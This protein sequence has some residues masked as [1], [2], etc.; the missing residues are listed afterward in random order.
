MSGFPSDLLEGIR[1]HLEAEKKS[2]QARINELKGQDP[3]SDPDRLND[4]A[5]TD[6]EANEESSHDR[7]SA[8]VEELNATLTQIDE[9]LIR[10][11]NGTYGSCS[12]CGKMINTD[13]LNIL[14]HAT[15][16]L[17][18]ERIKKRQK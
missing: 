16:C 5:A 8:M 2:A 13:R 11:G 6:A 14:A 3:F 15:L 1:I 10:I 4:N 12:N 9:A 7:F 18:C 17:A